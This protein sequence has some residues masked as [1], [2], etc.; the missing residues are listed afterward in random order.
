MPIVTLTTDFGWRDHYP[1]MIKGAMLCEHPQLTIVDITHSIKNY[2]IVQAAFL[3]RNTW[4]SFPKG[5][6]HLISVNDYYAPRTRFLATT[7]E[8]HYFI[9][10]DNGLFSLVFE[11]ELPPHFYELDYDE[12]NPFPLKDIYSQAVGYLAQGKPLIEIGL[13]AQDIERRITLQPVIGHS[14]IRGSII[15]V[16]NYDNAISNVSRELFDKVGAGRSFK[17][18][19]KRHSPIKRLSKDYHDLPVGEPLCLFNTAGYLEIAV[20]MGRACTLFGLKEEETIQIDF[21]S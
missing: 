12:G 21:H 13:P 6:I 1:A 20:N 19:F 16:D 4:R 11:E 3:F 8:G 10:P 5:T 9:A 17:L 14:Q 7:W 15:Y 18:Y 2:D